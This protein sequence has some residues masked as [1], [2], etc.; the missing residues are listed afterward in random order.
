VPLSRQRKPLGISVL[1]KLSE[2]D[3]DL[4][5]HG[6]FC[7]SL[8][9]ASRDGLEFAAEALDLKEDHLVRREK[10]RY[11]AGFTAVGTFTVSKEIL[12]DADPDMMEVGANYLGYG[13]SILLEE[14]NN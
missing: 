3:L 5:V 12:Y 7:Y 8:D 10:V 14:F 6:A 2:Y 1:G 11:G 9:R 13:T 4:P